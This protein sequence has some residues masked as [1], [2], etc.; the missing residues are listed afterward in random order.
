MGAVAMKE[1]STGFLDRG[2][3]VDEATLY[4]YCDVCG[5][6]KIKTYIPFIK[7]VI[8]AVIITAG[9]FLALGDKQWLMC[10]IPLGGLAV[11]LPWRDIFLGTSAGNV[12]IPR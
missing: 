2:Y 1:R 4:I 6:F 12:E 11:I 7:L 10:L 8:I 9:V 5:S 3:P